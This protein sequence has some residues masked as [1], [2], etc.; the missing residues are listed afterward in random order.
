MAADPGAA[1]TSLDARSVALLRLGGAISAGSAG[2]MWQQR[3]QDALDAGLSFDEIV[4]S[5]VALAPAIGIE[6]VV[7]VAPDLAGALGYNVDVA[8][9][10]LGDASTRN[11]LPTRSP[12]ARTGSPPRPGA[13]GAGPSH[14]PPT[15]RRRGGR[16]RVRS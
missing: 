13:P 3:V 11:G 8:L 6:R 1:R 15:C 10:G 12:P 16:P 5:L 14:V 4:D 9:E 2:P 7:A